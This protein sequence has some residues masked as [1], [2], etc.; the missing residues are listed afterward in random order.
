[1]EI[2][3]KTCQKPHKKSIPYCS[4]ECVNNDPEFHEICKTALNLVDA[5]RKCNIPETTFRRITE[6]LGVKITV[7]QKPPEIKIKICPK[8]SKEHTSKYG[9]HCSRSCAN[10]RVHSEETKNKISIATKKAFENNPELV[11]KLLE[12]RGT[13]K[14]S[15]KEKISKSLKEYYKNNPKKTKEEKLANNRA[16]RMAYYAKQKQATT[17]DADKKLIKKIYEN[18]PE[19][20]NVDHIIPINKGGLHHQDNLQYLP[21]LENR[22]KG[23]RLDYVPQGVIKW[24]DVLQLPKND[25]SAIMDM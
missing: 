24:Q 14:D 4:V 5:A 1:M 6:Q 2:F 9:I 15:S 3:C 21:V 10:G 17:A 20:Y 23:D 25:E 7:K 12:N 22:R 19:G 13:F 18:L 11:K 16:A 8:C